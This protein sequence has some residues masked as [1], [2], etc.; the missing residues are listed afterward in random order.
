[1]ETKAAELRARLRQRLSDSL[2]DSDAEICQEIDQ[3]LLEEAGLSL[4]ERLVLKEELYAGVRRLDVLQELMDDPEVTEIMVNG[5]EHIYVEKNG[6]LSLYGK[7]FASRERLEDVIQQIVAGCNRVINTGMPLADA[8]LPDGTRIHAAL[9]P[10]AVDGP[11]LTIRRFPVRAMD[12][13]DLLRMGTLDEE[14]AAFL[15]QLVRC[16][17]SVMIGGGTSAGKT[18]FLNA[19]SAYIPPGER[20]I[21]IEDTAELR[22]PGERNLVRLEAKNANLQEAR[23]ITIRDL[24]RAALRMRPDR[25]IVG[26]VRGEE[27]IDLLQAL[28]TGHDGSLSTAH[29]NS[30][31]DMLLRLETMALMGMAMPLEAIR[32]QIA[33][34]IDIFVQLGRDRNKQR[35]LL[36]IAEVTGFADGAVQLGKL[37]ERDWNSG[38]LCKKGELL[39]TEKLERAGI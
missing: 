11:V 29:A 38:R 2:K 30:A 27:T 26:E 6:Q 23:S 19:L 21:T 39:H 12:M 9:P 28:N 3:L 22:I 24:I 31:G 35:R 37:Y 10:V 34:G 13:E 17:Y 33:S 1:M 16:G 7:S 8:R 4:K 32:R 18:T 15:Q 20:L 14:T 25:I 5:H 36:E